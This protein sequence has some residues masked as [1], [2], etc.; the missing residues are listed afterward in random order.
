MLEKLEGDAFDISY[1]RSQV[2][3][4]QKTAQ[5]LEWEIGFGEDADVQRFASATLPVLEH[6]QAARDLQAELARL[7]LANNGGA[8]ALKHIRMV[9]SKVRAER[10]PRWPTA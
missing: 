4:H 3:D 8:S 1:I 10:N 2:V 7:A 9:A 5:L 6:L